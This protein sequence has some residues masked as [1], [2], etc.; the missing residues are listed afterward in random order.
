MAA[1]AQQLSP[2]VIGFLHSATE[3][4][5]APMTAAFRKSLT[6]AGYFDQS[7]TIESRWAQGRL[8]RLP[9]LAADLVRRQVSV[10][11]AGG[12]AEPALAAKAA[13]S[14]IPI[15]FAN[16]VD[17]VEV[18][19]VASLSRP[20]GNITGVTFLINTLGPKELEALHEL[21]PQANVI[22]AL[23]NP[24]LATT[25]SQAKDVE[26][27][28]PAL[29]LHVRVLHAS[30]EREIEAVFDSLAQMQAGG[31][32]IGANAFFF[33]RRNQLVELAARYSVPTVY[34]WREAVVAGG[35]MSYGANVADAYRLAG[36]YTGRV[37][38]GE[39]PADL[40]VQQSTNTELVI[41]LR[42]AKSL[43]LAF[44]ITLSGRA[45]QVIE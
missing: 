25:A 8:E 33:S 31:L 5:Y 40:P 43:G 24:D 35:L 38:K 26:M 41:N 13:T 19:L 20:G 42:T 14:K 18:G 6:E 7:V 36:D 45:D 21:R 22:A 2:P 34:P 12:G 15:V 3:G 9:E 37:L 28:A 10:I 1:L 16:G 23:I 44:P 4:A 30:T 29:G 39:K 32:V 11:F 27:A 17:P